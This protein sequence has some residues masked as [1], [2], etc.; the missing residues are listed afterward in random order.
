M[1]EV[2]VI[3]DL[4]EGQTIALENGVN[5]VVTDGKTTVDGKVKRIAG[6]RWNQLW[7]RFKEVN[8]DLAQQRVAE[9]VPA[10][11]GQKDISSSS[12]TTQDAGAQSTN[13]DSKPPVRARS[14]ASRLVDVSDKPNGIY[15]DEEDKV[16]KV[17]TSV[18][19]AQSLRNLPADLIDDSGARSAY[20]EAMRQINET[21]AD[22]ESSFTTSPENVFAILGLLNRSDQVDRSKTTL[23][24]RLTTAREH[25]DRISAK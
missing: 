8:P 4:L 3:R 9:I 16:Y 20:D 2:K 1:F 12:S 24:K 18:S 21:P 17:R 15:Y 13:A 14:A 7:D 5:V 25:Y 22:Q 23:V 6:M 19:Q 11:G 10:D